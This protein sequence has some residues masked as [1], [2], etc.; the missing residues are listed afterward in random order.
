[1]P[2]ALLLLIVGAGIAFYILIGYPLAL[3]ALPSRL[4]PPVAKDPLHEPSVS[5]IMAIYNGAPYVRAKMETILALDYPKPLLEIII[6]S[7]GSTDATV[8]IPGE[9]S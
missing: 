8:S 6:V 4:A 3:A 5:L 9:Y 2:I 7:D 1:M